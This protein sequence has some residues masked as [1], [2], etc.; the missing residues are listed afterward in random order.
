MTVPRPDT[1]ASVESPSAP[2]LNYKLRHVWQDD[3]GF[4]APMARKRAAA[5]AGG[6]YF[7]FL[8]GDCVPLG[9]FIAMHRRLAR[10]GWF[11]AATGSC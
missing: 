6:D 10:P 5:V 4:R 3:E 7:I 2:G 8:D 11:V 9:D 1:R